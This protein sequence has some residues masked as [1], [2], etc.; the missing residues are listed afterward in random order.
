MD[1]LMKAIMA[2][3]NQEIAE[4]KRKEQA[5]KQAVSNEH[6]DDTKKVEPIEHHN[7]AKNTE[8]VEHQDDAKKIETKAAETVH[9]VQP[10]SEP[11]PVQKKA[12]KVEQPTW[13]AETQET[14]ILPSM[15][16]PQTPEPVKEIEHHDDANLEARNEPAKVEP[17]PMPEIEVVQP[18]VDTGIKLFVGMGGS[19]F[20]VALAAAVYTALK[21]TGVM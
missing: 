13:S 21:V 7:D 18:K 11:A 1:D 12:K 2:K 9:V 4:A 8:T 20:V 6:H 10:K 16:E 19:F 15:L 14:C 5:T 3:A 17:A